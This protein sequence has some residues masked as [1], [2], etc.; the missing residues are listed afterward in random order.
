M[1]FPLFRD[2]DERQG[3]SWWT[4]QDQSA[5][6]LGSLATLMTKT[7]ALTDCSLIACA[8]HVWKDLTGV[9]GTGPYKAISD[10]VTFTFRS[11]KGTFGRL[12]IPGP[13]AA[14]FNADGKT[15]NLAQADVAAWLAQVY[16][17]LGDS[18][19]N[20]WQAV[21]LARRRKITVPDET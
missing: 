4:T 20:P 19:G 9:T 3:G 15:V 12:T 13:K 11:S 17:L 6:V 7:Q 18:E 16:A 10:K 2:F 8:I 21:T 1:A 14:I 5:A